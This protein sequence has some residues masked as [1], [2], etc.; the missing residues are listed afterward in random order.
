MNNKSEVINNIIKQTEPKRKILKNMFRA[1]IVGGI[2]CLIAQIFESLFC[3]WF[4]KEIAHNLAILSMILIS[5]ILTSFGVY[6]RIGQFAG[7]GTIIPITGF[8][9]S[10]TSSAME[11]KS[12]GLVTGIINNML[13]LAGSVIVTG[14]ISAFIIGSLVYVV[15]LF[16]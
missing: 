5:S 8:A 10:V 16:L 13:K 9:N 3:L 6:D 15:G 11:Y 2:V 7:A 14:V 1:F 4:D 12:E